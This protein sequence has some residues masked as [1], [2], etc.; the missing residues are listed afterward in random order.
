MMNLFVTGT[1]TDVGKTVSTLAILQA[2]NTQGIK[3][4]GYKPIADQCID[5][6]EGVRNKDALLI[7]SVSR[8]L[9]SYDEVNP[10]RITDNYSHKNSIDFD[11]IKQGLT[12][13]NEQCDVVVIEGNGGWRYLLDDNTFYAD[14]LKG[15]SVGVIL[16]VGIQHGCVNHAL[17]TADAIRAD[18]LT[19][20]GWIANR[21]NPGLAHY[22]QI[23]E[24]LQHHIKSPLL[25]EIPYL[26]R[27]EERDLGH[28][29]DTEKLQEFICIPA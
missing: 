26:L 3:A 9:V 21:I 14:W 13:L 2:L 8:N 15:Q 4:V 24:R 6:P 11:K 12:H 5:T 22:A 25:G 20:A 28:Y 27:P 16:V 18:G 23:I 1:D 19:I 17:L 29:L 10:I 7:Q